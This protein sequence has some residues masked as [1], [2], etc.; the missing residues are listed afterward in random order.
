MYFLKKEKIQAHI[1]KILEK[2][3]NVFGA[4]IMKVFRMNL[5]NNNI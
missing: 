4:E 1:K 2:V 5:S 3:H